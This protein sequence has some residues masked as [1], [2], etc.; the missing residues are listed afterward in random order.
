MTAG[1]SKIIV[2]DF[3][4]F[5]PVWPRREGRV[6]E[7]AGALFRVSGN[8]GIFQRHGSAYHGPRG[9]VGDR[10]VTSAITLPVDHPA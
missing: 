7:R 4:G 9:V 6:K 10:R 2:V 5:T 1:V 3:P 8:V